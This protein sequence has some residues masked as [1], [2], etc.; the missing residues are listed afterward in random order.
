[1]DRVRVRVKGRKRERG[2]WWWEK[3][4]KG[5]RRGGGSEQMWVSVFEI[6]QKKWFLFFNFIFVYLRV[7]ET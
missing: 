5:E 6:A 7:R 1:M 3:V 4:T 2:E